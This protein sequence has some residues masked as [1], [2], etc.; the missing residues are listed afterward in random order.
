MGNGAGIGPA[1]AVSLPMA[2]MSIKA[3]SEAGI[4]TPEIKLPTERYDS[5]VTLGSSLLQG[6]R[7]RAGGAA[8]AEP[9]LAFSR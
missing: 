8:F 2:L 5:R 3:S 7:G 6:L 1:F 9:A 4:A